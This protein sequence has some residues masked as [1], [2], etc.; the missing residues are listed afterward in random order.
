MFAVEP[1]AIV[2]LVGTPA[3]IWPVGGVMVMPVRGLIVTVAVAVLPAALAVT[4]ASCEV[5]NVV[6]AVPLESVVTVPGLTVPFVVV[7]VT[8]TAASPTPL[9][10]STRAE[11]VLEPPEHASACGLAVNNK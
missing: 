11:T 3:E 5:V 4:V 1:T 6:A 8:G 2:K 7:N 10:S 9:T